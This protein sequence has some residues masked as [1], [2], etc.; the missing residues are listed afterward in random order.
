MTRRLLVLLLAALAVMA[1]GA[2]SAEAT[3]FSRTAWD[4]SIDGKQ[5]VRWSFAA[6]KPENCSS[7]YGTASEEA[8]GSGS[9]SMSFATKK[10]Q[11]LWA[12]TYLSGH[13]LKFMSFSTDG[14]QIPAVFTEKGKFSVTPGMP[15][16]SKPGDPTP[17][18]RVADTS[19]CGTVN[20]TMGPYLSWER[21]KFQ[22]LG[23]I[24]PT[25]LPE[26]CPG[27]FELEMWVDSDAPCL[28]KEGM[29]GIEGSPLQELTVKVGS[30]EF[31][32]GKTFDVDANE[33]FQ[34]E[35]PSHWEGE[36]PLKLLLQTKYQVTFKPRSH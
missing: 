27:P 3:I 9:I 10:K 18:P 13:K 7:Y 14:W 21:G 24:E 33:K 11:P 20:T 4:V 22:L 2:A 15:C 6:E 31:F 23:G 17:L 35:F 25:F 30:D 8:V 12:E 1:C 36:P 29:S 34:C 26:R 28:P 19:E 32:K 16:G 5:T